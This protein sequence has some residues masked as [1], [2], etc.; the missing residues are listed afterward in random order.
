MELLFFRVPL[1]IKFI[2]V[3]TSSF[4]PILNLQ[5]HREKVAFSCSLA[6]GGPVL[7]L[8]QLGLFLELGA[9]SGDSGCA[10]GTLDPPS[11]EQGPS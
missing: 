9:L 4:F 5:K 8:E 2:Y 11:M 3:L 1:R 7:K 10:F 6:L